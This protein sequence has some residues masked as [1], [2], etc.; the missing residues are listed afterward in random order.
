ME[1]IEL[2]YN[3]D[4]SQLFE[5]F[6]R[7]QH[8]R[9]AMDRLLEF[10]QREQIGMDHGFCDK[11][12]FGKSFDEMLYECDLWETAIHEKYKATKFHRHTPLV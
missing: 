1:L 7:V 12:P 3:M 6:L 10:V 2:D 11:Y 4:R 5:L 8:M 9:N